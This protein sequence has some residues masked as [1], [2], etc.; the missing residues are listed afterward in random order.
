MAFVGGPRFGVAVGMGGSV[1]VAAW[2][3]L[4]PGEVYRPAYHVSEV[5]VRNVNIVH[6]TNVT[7]INNVNVTN[8]RYVN[9]NVAGAVTVVSGTRFSQRGKASFRNELYELIS[10]VDGRREREMAGGSTCGVGCHLES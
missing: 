4:G 8:V 10:H 9:Q 2:F 3:P 7:V 6:V 5:Y 1:G